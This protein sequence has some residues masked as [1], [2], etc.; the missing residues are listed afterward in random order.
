MKASRFSAYLGR[1]R[2]LLTLLGYQESVTFG[3][4]PFGIF[5]AKHMNGRR[6]VR[7]WEQSMEMPT[8]YVSYGHRVSQ[9]KIRLQTSPH[10]NITVLVREKIDHNI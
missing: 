5:K 7:K 3:L 9:K 4:T 2:M 6:S 8:S 10:K 1:L